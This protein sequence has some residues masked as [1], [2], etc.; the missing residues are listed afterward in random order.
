[1]IEE[2]GFQAN[3]FNNPKRPRM[4]QHNEFE[5]WDQSYRRLQRMAG[6]P[7]SELLRPERVRRALD[8]LGIKFRQ[9]VFC[10]TITL[11]TFL[12]QVLS[13]DHSCREAVGRL[14]AW[15]VAQ[16]QPACSADTTSYC[17][18]RQ[19]LPVELV[20]Q[21][22]RDT[23]RELNE[24]ADPAWLWRG[25]HVKI[26]DGTTVSMPD[27]PDNR[28]AYPPPRSQRPGV[29]FPI[30]RV[31]V[32]FSLACATVLEAA[33]GPLSGKKTGELSLFRGL[34]DVLQAGDVLLVDRLFCTFRDIAT[35]LARGVDL[36]VRQ[37]ASR[38]TDFR[39][40][41]WLGTQ[42]HVVVWHRPAFASRRFD[43]VTWQALP[44]RIEV[45]ELRFRVTQRGFRPQEITLVTTLLDPVAYPAD[46]LSL[47][48]RERWHC[49]LDLRSLKVSMQMDRLRCKTPEMV[50][51]ELWMHLLAYNLIRQTVAEAARSHKIAPR[52]LS[53]KGA[54]Q[55]VN[56]MATYLSFLRPE[57]ERL[58]KELLAAIATHNVGN[59]P[60]RI[61]PRK[62][63]YRP[64][65]YTYLTRPRT[66]ER[67]RLCA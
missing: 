50:E 38:R 21:L 65:K 18:A 35:Q 36:V 66:E 5:G 17:H 61:E 9:R 33:M 16:G 29:G 34:D 48:F 13:A 27:T 40:G 10:P 15:R 46:E 32:V 62:L 58:W 31:L 39:R 28:A 4:S 22:V 63:K 56:S 30:A 44:E 7:F 14:L 59:R 25:R 3:T 43:R 20:R 45:R 64:G 54:V 60:N 53:F 49:E 2:R 8:A 1:V 6:L 52:H 11:W 42:D 19:R 23:G 67:Q 47:L 57:R 24:Q 12:S 41:R 55:L 37:H 51:K 26:A